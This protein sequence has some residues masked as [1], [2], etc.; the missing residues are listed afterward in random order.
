MNIIKRA[1]NYITK[2]EKSKIDILL[3]HLID[4][5]EVKDDVVVIKTSKNILLEND[6]HVVTLT[7][8]V[9]VQIAKEIHLN[10]E[11]NFVESEFPILEDKL[12]IE[13]TVLSH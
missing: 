3:N 11:L 8:G 13:N 9:S 10:P 4:S 12:Q 7:K 5:I 6:G 2:S 1:I